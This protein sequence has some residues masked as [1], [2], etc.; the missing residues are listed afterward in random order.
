M[1]TQIR[2]ALARDEIVDITTL[3]R[4][5]GQPRRVEIWFRRLDRKIYITGTPGPRGWYANLLA[6]PRLV[7]HL[8]QSVQADLPAIAHPVLDEE[9]RRRI[10]SAPCMSWYHDQ[11]ESLDS[12][13]AG[14]PLIEVE[15][16]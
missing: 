1:D 15:L 6:E 13:V 7:F 14:S 5:S 8:K 16:L 11:V 3:G 10:L 2:D 12:L 4:H 9:E